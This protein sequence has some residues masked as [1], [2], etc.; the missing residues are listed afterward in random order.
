MLGDL[1]WAT[2]VE[3]KSDSNAFVTEPMNKAF[4]SGQFNKVAVMIGFTSQEMISFIFSK[5]LVIFK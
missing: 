3:P 2:V 1:K 4:E 5:F